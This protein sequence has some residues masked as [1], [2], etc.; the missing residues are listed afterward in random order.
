MNPVPIGREL[1]IAS[2]PQ[3]LT[4]DYGFGL[5]YL[6]PLSETHFVSEDTRDTFIIERDQEGHIIQVWAEHLCFLEATAAARDGRMEAALSWL[7]QAV[8]RFPQS[9]RAHVNLSQVLLA[10]GDQSE[11]RKSVKRA[12]EIDPQHRRANVLQRQFY[13]KRIGRTIGIGAISVIALYV[14]R[15]WLW[16]RI[17]SARLR[18]SGLRLQ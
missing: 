1:A 4:I 7:K 14:F 17:R 12:L 8:A 16:H 15:S 5:Y 11:A 10:I 18:C 9:A 13:M 6:R 3:G 2:S